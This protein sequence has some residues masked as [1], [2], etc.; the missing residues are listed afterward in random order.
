VKRTP[1]TFF[2]TSG[3]EKVADSVKGVKKN[4]AKHLEYQNKS[5]NIQFAKRGTGTACI[6]AIVPYRIMQDDDGSR[7]KKKRNT[8]NTVILAVF[9]AHKQLSL[10]CGH[11]FDIIEAQNNLFLLSV[12]GFMLILVVKK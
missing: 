8:R 1:T 9:F 12:C 3:Q 6:Q 10:M 2:K 5:E 7:K 4:P 11:L